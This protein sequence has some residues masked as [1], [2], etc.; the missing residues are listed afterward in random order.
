[1]CP[2]V[3]AF[4]ILT[5]LLSGAYQRVWYQVLSGDTSRCEDG[6][7]TVHSLLSHAPQP[8]TLPALRLTQ[9]LLLQAATLH[10]APSRIKALLPPYHLAEYP[11][12]SR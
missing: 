5:P 9:Q 1:M 8:I 4:P 2:S 12:L 6:V 11:L 10:H 3:I 7:N